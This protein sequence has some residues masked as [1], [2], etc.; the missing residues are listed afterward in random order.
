MMAKLDLVV[1][2]SLVHSWLPVANF[3]LT[4]LMHTQMVIL[5]TCKENPLPFSEH[6]KTQDES[7]GLIDHHFSHLP[8]REI[9]SLWAWNTQDESN[10]LID[11]H[12]FPFT[13]NK[14]SLFL[15]M[16]KHKVSLLCLINIQ[17][18]SFKFSKHKEN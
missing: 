5:C 4:P 13:C 18:L 2:T 1:A 6:G 16:E 12:F 11:H 9:L 8:A 7:T 10:G 3:L 17:K 14:N 15:R